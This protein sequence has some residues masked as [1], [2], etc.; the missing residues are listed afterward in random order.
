MNLLPKTHEKKMHKEYA[1]RFVV[2]V[3]WAVAML[4][5][6]WTVSLVPSL[7]ELRVASLE[8]DLVQDVSGQNR[9]SVQRQILESEQ[10]L[11]AQLALVSLPATRMQTYTQ[12]IESLTHGD[13]GIDLVT[14]SFERHVPTK[15]E[16]KPTVQA[17]IAG[18]A[19]NR[20]TLQTM[21]ELLQ[22]HE[23]VLEVDVPLSSFTNST[24]I[25]FTAIVTLTEIHMK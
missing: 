11:I 7:N 14:L 17:T 16:P 9:A 15:E 2:T 10:Q 23:S 5:A 3:L 24:N 18:R 13:A 19:D 20:E 22:A 4:I 8:Q 6:V 25:P 12:F 1:L 21:I